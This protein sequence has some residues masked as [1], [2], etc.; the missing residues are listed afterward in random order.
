MT[1]KKNNSANLQENTTE[2]KEE[3]LVKEN[4][5]LRNAIGVLNERLSAALE[6][7]EN[8][9]NQSEADMNILLTPPEMDFET[10]YNDKEKRAEIENTYK[11]K[12]GEY[13]KAKLLEEMSPMIEDYKR[14]TKK[15]EFDRA[16]NAIIKDNKFKSFQ[17]LLPEAEALIEKHSFLRE[18]SPDKAYITAYLIARGVEAERNPEKPLGERLEE[19]LKDP[20]IIKALEEKRAKAKSERKSSSPILGASSG[21]GNVALNLKEK[22]KSL[23]EAY[24]QTLKE[25]SI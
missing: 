8:Q 25:F 12:L 23:D 16:K 10:A 24:R 5:E 3:A 13:T 2:T 17:A 19:L 14:L 4:L 21:A 20:S 18:M 7:L 1:E 9:K 15:A 11:Q 6:E 22:P